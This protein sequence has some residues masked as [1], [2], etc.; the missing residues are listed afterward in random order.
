MIPALQEMRER[1]GMASEHGAKSSALRPLQWTL[2][3]ILSAT[4]AAGTA[5]MDPAI[6]TAGAAASGLVLLTLL[7]AYVFFARRD[8]DAL[9]SEQYKIYKM[10]IE[11][12]ALGDDKRGLYQMNN[13]GLLHPLQSEQSGSREILDI[14]V[15]PAVDAEEDKGG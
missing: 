9:R 4:I 6:V 15:E 14:T 5:G 3:I 1:L 8:P 12:G 2:G 7:G 11:R 10:A 13:A